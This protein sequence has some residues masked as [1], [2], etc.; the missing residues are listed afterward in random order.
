MQSRSKYILLVGIFFCLSCI[1]GMEQGQKL[2]N[3]FEQAHQFDDATQPMYFGYFSL[4]Q[5]L[6]AIDYVEKRMKENGKNSYCIKKALKS[7]ISWYIEWLQIKLENADTA[8]FFQYAVSKNNVGFLQALNKV[9]IRY[10][11]NEWEES[12]F[13]LVKSIR[14]AQILIDDFNI[15]LERIDASAIDA[16]SEE[17]PLIIAAVSDY[18]K[19]A[20]LV[21]FYIKQGIN[22]HALDKKFGRNALFALA[23][24]NP[25]FSGLRITEEEENNYRNDYL[26]K[27]ELLLD[28][29]IDHKLLDNDGISIKEFIEIRKTS[30]LCNKNS[31]AIC[32]YYDSLIKLIEAKDAEST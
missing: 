8:D 10:N 3:M 31:D 22:I 2:I 19:P 4:P 24:I 32:N 9:G 14:V 1:V 29:E 12:P 25:D 16:V 28:A 20:S 17:K 7:F 5:R 13:S 30:Y 23:S 15:P 6:W 11:K 21:E 18:C 27:A 26:K